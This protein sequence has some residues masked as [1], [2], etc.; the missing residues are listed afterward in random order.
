MTNT[1]TKEQIDAILAAS[2]RQD[3]KLGAKTTVVHLTLPNG[4]EIV[5]S[6][7]CVDPANY[8][9]DIGV[10]VCMGRLVNRVWQLEGY[11][12]QYQLSTAAG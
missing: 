4:F 5:E 9:H 12:L 3:M 8:D 1:I 10:V 2:T 11:R 6:S 7:A